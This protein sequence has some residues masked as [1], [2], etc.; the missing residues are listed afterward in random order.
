M[1]KKSEHD[2]MVEERRRRDFGFV[3]PYDEHRKLNKKEMPDEVFERYL[4]MV[5]NSEEI[6]RMKIIKTLHKAQ[7]EFKDYL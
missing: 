4:D 1:R 7:R 6:D 2:I 3:I 5:Y